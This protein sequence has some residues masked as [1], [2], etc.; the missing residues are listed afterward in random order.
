ME[1]RSQNPGVR[2]VTPVS[3]KAA[4]WLLKPS[5]NSFRTLLTAASSLQSLSSLCSLYSSPLGYAQ[6]FRHV[7]ELD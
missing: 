3:S 2:E 1:A 7:D 6:R 4:P 5:R